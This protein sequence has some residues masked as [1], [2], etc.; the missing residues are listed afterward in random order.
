MW[1]T[2]FTWG[3]QYLL[4]DDMRNAVNQ[5]IQWKLSHEVITHCFIFSKVDSM[6]K[7]QSMKDVALNFPRMFLK[8][9]STR[10]TSFWTHYLLI[11][12]TI[13]DGR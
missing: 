12:F 6:K 13:W 11:K 10:D 5:F 4:K 1:P 2:A 8:D 3:G 7:G 9:Y